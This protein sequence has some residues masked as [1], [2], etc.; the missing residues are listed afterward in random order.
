M[1]DGRDPHLFG[2]FSAVAQRIGVYTV[3]DY[4]DSLEFLIGRWRLEKIEG[5]TSEGKHAQELVCGLAPKI[6]RLQER[7]D[8]RVKKMKPKFSWIFNKEMA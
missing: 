8:E 1:H 5:L 3:S 2:H 7:A 6:R 4:I